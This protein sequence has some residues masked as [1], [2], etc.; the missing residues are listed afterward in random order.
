M[1]TSSFHATD[2]HGRN[3]TLYVTMA[4]SP[5]LLIMAVTV[6][7][8]VQFENF[9][10]RYHNI[11]ISRSASP[12]GHSADHLQPKYCVEISLC[13]GSAWTLLGELTA[14][15]RYPC[16]PCWWEELALPS[17][18]PHPRLQGPSPAKR[19]SGTNL[20]ETCHHHFWLQ[21]NRAS[22]CRPVVKVGSRGLIWRN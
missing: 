16:R 20:Y 5:P 7:T 11:T 2:N 15:P 18:E 1:S 3:L 9:Q 4:I 14:P 12:H 10:T 8:T 19:K 17:Q 6:T 21:G 22:V 13:W